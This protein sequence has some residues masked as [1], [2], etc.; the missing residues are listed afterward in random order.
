MRAT[1]ALGY[2]PSYEPTDLDPALERLLAGLGGLERWVKPGQRVLLKPN[3]I[4]ASP[5]EHAAT[6][7]PD[8]LAALCR[9]VAALGA[10][11]VIGDAPAWGGPHAVAE[12]TGMRRLCDELGVEFVFFSGHARLPSRHPQVTGH[13]RVDPRVLAADV[14][15][16]VPKLK[17]HQQLG[18]TAA[19]KN[20]YGCLSGRHKALHHC[21][22]DPSFARYLVAYCAALPITLHIVDGILAM[23]GAGPRLGQ[24]RPLGVIAAATEPVALDTT[25]ADVIGVPASH[26]FL[27]DAARELGVGVGDVSQIDVVGQ[28]VAELAVA[29]FVFPDLLGV[30]FSPW[31]LLRGYFRNRRMM[32]E[33]AALLPR[34]THR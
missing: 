6:T 7:H 30:F 9:R 24:A 18:F 14:V 23:E 28:T 13:F 16:N 15:I 17:A 25:L 1:V 27:L 10:T 2:C 32:R 34:A 22:S 33:D 29:D 19:V 21:A 31:R 26:R 20:C 8:F 12:T 5:P 11:P 3:L 4:S